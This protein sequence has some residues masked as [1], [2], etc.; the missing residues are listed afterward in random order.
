MSGP[1][2]HNVRFREATIA[3]CSA[4]A[5]VHVRS[6]QESFAGIVPQIFLDG[7]SVERRA[8]AFEEGF[9]APSYKMYVAESAGHGV[10][11]FVDCGAPR[12][13]VG[14]YAGE[15]Y[16]VYILPEFQRRGVG[17][18]LF[19]LAAESLA[20]E[21]RCS[22]Y[23][24]ALEASPYRSFYEKM[25]GKVVGRKQVEMVGAR[26]DELVYGWDSLC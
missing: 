3:D 13:N 16:A 15:L 9:A 17:Q 24:Y 18:K 4:V 10:I 25:G 26:F 23:L 7:M 6:W 21:G 19:N 8:R 20:G 22:M 14:A 11:G 5:R 2:V 12:E 1:P